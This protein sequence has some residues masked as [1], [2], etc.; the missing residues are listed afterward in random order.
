MPI[1]DGKVVRARFTSLKLD[2]L[3]GVDRPAQSDALAVIMKR[4]DGADQAAE[5][6][7]DIAKYVCADDGAHTFVEVLAE[8]KF[9]EQIWPFTDALS[10]SI[11]SIVGD[12]GLSNADREAKITKELEM[13]EL[14]V[15]HE[16]SK[17]E[18]SH[19]SL[20]LV[21]LVR[22]RLLKDL[23]RLHECW[24]DRFDEFMYR[25]KLGVQGFALP[26]SEYNP[27]AFP[28]AKRLDGPDA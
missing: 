5:I 26:N 25:S 20:P 2:E 18:M 6:Y 22:I 11:R 14:K 17:K 4:H 3:S 8:N 13:I 15:Q 24:K 10:Q 19:Q 12:R 23:D 28:D 1:I 16:K 7:S 27:Q 9:S 21:G